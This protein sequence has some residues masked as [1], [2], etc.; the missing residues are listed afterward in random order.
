MQHVVE[1]R[2]VAPGCSSVSDQVSQAEARKEGNTYLE[3]EP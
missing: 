2:L 1:H 3:R